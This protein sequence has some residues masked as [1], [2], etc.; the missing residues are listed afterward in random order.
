MEFITLQQEEEKEGKYFL[1]QYGITAG[2]WEC[3][4]ELA[5]FLNR[6]YGDPVMREQLILTC[7]ASHGL[8]LLLNTVLSPNG[9]IFVEEL[10]Y[11]IALEAFKQFPLMKIITGVPQIY[12]FLIYG[13]V[14]FIIFLLLQYP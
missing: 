5:K 10:T 14:I 8:Q 11:M 2:L 1:F 7:G 6:R 3:R 9:V 13:I 12:H 4:D